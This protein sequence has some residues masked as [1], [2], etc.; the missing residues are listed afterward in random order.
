M[1]IIVEIIEAAFCLLARYT[2]FAYMFFFF[3]AGI[4]LF[5]TAF[6]PIIARD[7]FEMPALKPWLQLLLGLISFLIGLGCAVWHKGI[8]AKVEA[9]GRA[10]AVF[11]GVLLLLPLFTAPIVQSQRGYV[12]DSKAKHSMMSADPSQWVLVRGRKVIRTATAE[13]IKRD[14]HRESGGSG[15]VILVLRLL[16]LLLGSLF[17][18]RGLFMI[19]KRRPNQM[20][21]RQAPPQ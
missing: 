15:Q 11:G 12:G 13:D 4:F 6:F 9:S 18:I 5:G 20:T 10:S 17:L 3:C 16:P 14:E 19:V 2:L 7:V 8:T 1:K 21:P